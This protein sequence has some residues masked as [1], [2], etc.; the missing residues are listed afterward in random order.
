MTDPIKPPPLPRRRTRYIVQRQFQVKYAGWLL[1]ICALVGWLAGATVYMMAMQQ[2][3]TKIEQIY[4]QS[5]AVAIFQS[6]QLT[7]VRNLLWLIPVLLIVS[8]GMSHKIAGPMVRIKRMVDEIGY[9]DVPGPITLRK[10]DEL[11]DLAASLNA[12]GQRL[13]AKTAVQQQTIEAMR[14]T[15]EELGRTLSGPTVDPAQARRILEALQ[16]QL[17]ALNGSPSRGESPK[18]SG[19]SPS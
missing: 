19:P 10:H 15:V 2:L 5:R 7:L 16:R 1:V 3:G 18:P 9:D 12:M 4:P 8:V 6:T 13:R 14:S 11:R 17:G